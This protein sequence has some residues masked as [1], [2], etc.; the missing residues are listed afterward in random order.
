MPDIGPALLY[1]LNESMQNFLGVPPSFLVILTPQQW[2][3]SSIMPHGVR[4]SQPFLCQPF[5][6]H[7]C[8]F[9]PLLPPRLFM[10]SQGPIHY[11][12][13]TVTMTRSQLGCQ[14]WVALDPASNCSPQ[15]LQ[16]IV[17]ACWS[18]GICRDPYSAKPA[19]LGLHP[20]DSG[21]G[22]GEGCFHFGVLPRW[23]H[24]MIEVAWTLNI[25]LSGTLTFP[26]L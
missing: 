24:A 4:R 15:I 1:L 26:L 20:G 21:P 11:L 9:Y 16:P 17:T 14:F 5:H 3:R 25:Q 2:S 10:M 7:D 12:L 6:Q 13:T 18:Q 19:S 22:R 23:G 8:S